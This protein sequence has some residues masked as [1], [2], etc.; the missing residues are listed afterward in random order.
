MKTIKQLIEIK[1]KKSWSW[2]YVSTI[3]GINK[4]TLSRIV[5]GHN[6]PIKAHEDILIRLINRNKNT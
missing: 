4:Y 2:E 5:N 6:K 1:E 3:T